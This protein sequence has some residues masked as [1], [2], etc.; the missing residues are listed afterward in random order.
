MKYSVYTLADPRDGAIHYVGISK[1]V[2][3]RYYCHNTPQGDST[4]RAYPWISRLKEQGLKPLLSVIEEVDGWDIAY[5]RETYWM[6][7]F[8][9]EEEPLSNY[10]AP[11]RRKNKEAIC[12][13]SE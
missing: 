8:L 7:F 6:N 5:E 4:S 13:G 10:V 11:I 1:D 9:D 2:K 3:W 12:T